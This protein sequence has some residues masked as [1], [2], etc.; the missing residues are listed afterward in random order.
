MNRLFVCLA[1]SL[2]LVPGIV[3]AG[4]KNTKDATE[5]DDRTLVSAIDLSKHTIVLDHMSHDIKTTYVLAPD[6]VVQI[7]GKVVTANDI[8][9]GLQLKLLTLGSGMDDPQVIEELDL[10]N[11]DAAPQPAA[12][13]AA[14]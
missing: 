3:L 4:E 12:K 13:K 5:S 8:K 1:L 9:V 2:V 6:I 10:R 14:K 7:S 11:G